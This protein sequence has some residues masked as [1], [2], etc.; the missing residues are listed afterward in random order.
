M[1]WELRTAWA[2][3]REVI[4]VC[5]ADRQRVRGYVQHVA[6][7]DAFALVWDG[8]GDAHVPLALVLAVR[9]PHFSAPE[10]G[11]RVEPPE[12]PPPIVVLAGQLQFEMADAR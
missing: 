12:R 1:A 5:A 11:G 10:D 6:P 3:Q 7:T 4:V 9:R 8:R 2:S